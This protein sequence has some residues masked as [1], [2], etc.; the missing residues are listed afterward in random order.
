MH[1]QRRFPSIFIFLC[2]L[3]SLLSVQLAA[4]KFVH[5]GIDQNSKDLAKMKQLVLNGV[6]P[7]K[8]AFERLKSATDSGFVVASH[9]H[10]LRGPYGRPNIGG[11]DLSKSAAM[12][13]NYAL[14]WYI[15]NDKTY[16]SKAIEILNAWSPVLW[17]LDYNDAKLL[18][19]WTGHALCNAAEILRY[20]NAGWQQKDID[21]F[22]DMLM[23]VYYPLMRF[24][25][26]QANGNWDGAII[27]SILAIAVFTDNR[28]MFDNA[29]DHYLHAPV[30]GSIFKYI[31]P[32][33]QCQETMRD[34]G[35]VQLGLGEFAGAAQIASTQGVDLF[36]IADNRLGL[37]YEYTASFLLG[38]KPQSYGTKSERAKDIRDDY[39]YVYRHYTAKGVD[40]PYTK[41]AADSIRPSASRSVLTS[42]RLPNGKASTVTKKVKAST[43]GY[44]A[45]A[46]AATK[47]SF[48]A[49][50][51]LV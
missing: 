36:S 4:Q 13:Y 47:L 40:L 30:N 37:G 10:V 16:A 11:N 15:S 38:E 14:A 24:Y 45:G 44:V 43:I 48:P 18:A 50:A 1:D 28:K 35:H 17:H 31:Y 22:T 7:Y 20:T 12:A 32:N 46:G 39:E 3:T 25:Y 42:V 8:D 21:A 9:R 23:T 27:H 26:P 41:R 33:G 19:A 51:I 5:P 2:V 29:I 6:Q 34:Q 49:D